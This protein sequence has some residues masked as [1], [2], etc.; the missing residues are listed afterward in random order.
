MMNKQSTFTAR[1]TAI[2]CVIGCFLT[3][4][5]GLIS[6]AEVEPTPEESSLVGESTEETFETTAVEDMNTTDPWETE[7]PFETTDPW[8]TEDPFETTDPWET[9]DPFETTDPWETTDPFETTDPWE[10][11]DPFETTDPWETTDPFETTAPLPE[12][13]T[14]PPVT[15][16]LRPSTHPVTQTGAVQSMPNSPL[17]TDPVSGHVTAQTVPGKTSASA[18]GGTE[19]LPATPSD[20]PSDTTDRSSGNASQEEGAKNPFT[21][22]MILASAIF[23]V[24]AIVSIVA[25]ILTKFMKLTPKE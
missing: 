16:T 17:S 4:S 6:L 22:A 13:T 23:A 3:L 24:A 2:L 15:T 9:E 25:V 5:G 14:T 18:P 12:V 1:L 10:T 19:D 20:D 8:E 21:T 11:T 7:D